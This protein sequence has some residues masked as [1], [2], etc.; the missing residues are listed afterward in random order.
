MISDDALA[1]VTPPLIIAQTA[2]YF[3]LSIEDLTGSSRS[4]TLVSARQ[5]AM[6]LCRE[7]T[8]MSLE[9]IGVQFGGRHHTTVM[10]AFDKISDQMAQQQSIYNKVTELTARIKQQ[11]NAG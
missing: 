5:I 7:M 2:S 3:G 11:A 1:E 9:K 4:R 10:N 8:S 6:Y